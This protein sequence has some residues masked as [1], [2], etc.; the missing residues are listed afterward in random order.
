[1]VTAVKERHATRH[2]VSIN[3]D[4]CKDCY[5][6]VGLCRREIFVKTSRLNWR[7]M[8]RVE[9]KNSSDCAGCLDCEVQCPDL[10]ITIR[11]A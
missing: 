8:P 4:W 7:G 11:G 3:H 2:A 6:C 9:V 1:M 5:I 10:A